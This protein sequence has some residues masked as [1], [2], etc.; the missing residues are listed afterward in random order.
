MLK[1]RSLLDTERTTPNDAPSRSQRYSP[2]QESSDAGPGAILPPL[3]DVVQFYKSGFKEITASGHP[4]KVNFGSNIITNTP[5]GGSNSRIFDQN[6]DIV[7]LTH[8]LI[9]VCL[10]FKIQIK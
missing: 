10:V 7:S 8:P 4:F 5:A 2:R 3:A 9:F 6:G 1:D